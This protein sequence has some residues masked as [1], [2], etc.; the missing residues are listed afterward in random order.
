LIWNF[1]FSIYIKQIFKTKFLLESNLVKSLVCNVCVYTHSFCTSF[2]WKKINN[3]F[4]EFCS[5]TCPFELKPKRFPL[6]IWSV[7]EM[8]DLNAG[9]D[10]VHINFSRPL[11]LSNKDARVLG[12]DTWLCISTSFDYDEGPLGEN[13]FFFGGIHISGKSLDYIEHFDRSENCCC[14][15]PLME[16]ATVKKNKIILQQFAKRTLIQ[17]YTTNLKCTAR[18]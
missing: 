14:N 11:T 2:S 15:T 18:P 5:K 16:S 13:I 4:I 17:F 10:Y 12:S 6:E 7:H 3:I 8:T 1:N 9:A